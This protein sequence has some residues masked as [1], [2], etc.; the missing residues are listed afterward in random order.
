MVPV[1]K[2]ARPDGREQEQPVERRITAGAVLVLGGLSGICGCAGG[3]ESDPPSAAA[4]LSGSPSSGTISLDEAGV[5]ALV[6]SMA[7]DYSAVLAE[8]VTANMRTPESTPRQR[9]LAT[10]VIRSWYADA[11]DIAIGPNPETSLLDLLVVGSL[12]AHVMRTQF[13][14]REWPDLDPQAVMEPI[15]RAEQR[16]WRESSKV[17]TPAQQESLRSLIDAWIAEHPERALIAGTRLSDFTDTRGISSLAKRN[18]AAALLREVGDAARAI[19]ESRLLGERVLW[20]SSR[21]PSVLSLQAELLAYQLASQQEFVDLH[22]EIVN[23]GE[24]SERFATVAESLPQ[25]ID[26]SLERTAGLVAQEREAAINHLG[27]MVAA[28]REALLDHLF[29]RIADERTALLDDLESRT[30]ALHTALAETRLTI[31]QANALLERTGE[32]LTMTDRVVARFDPNEPPFIPVSDMEATQAAIESGADLVDRLDQLVT[33]VEALAS[34]TNPQE[35]GETIHGIGKGLLTSA[36][37]ML[38][39]VVAFLLVGSLLVGAVLIRMRAGVAGA[40]L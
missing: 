14:P 16:L 19:D 22:A 25:T 38:M 3:P 4:K 27:E 33:R 31:E 36:F 6:M 10:Y 24:Q 11:L 1:C 29:E 5:Q 15:T 7:D 37:W 21:L 17:L 8:T 2:N 32:V 40:R 34:T 12:Q 9:Y 23:F 20:Y 28:E 39:G 35:A 30:D 18:Q 13:L 26:D